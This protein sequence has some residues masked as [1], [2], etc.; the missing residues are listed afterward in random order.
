[1]TTTDLD[2]APGLRLHD[3]V[4]IVGL[5][6]L[7]RKGMASI[8]RACDDVIEAYEGRDELLAAAYCHHARAV[9]AFLV[10]DGAEEIAG[11]AVGLRSVRVATGVSLLEG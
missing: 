5:R 1:M 8:L 4:G 2:R 9:I 11:L 3:V 7:N 10:H 6:D